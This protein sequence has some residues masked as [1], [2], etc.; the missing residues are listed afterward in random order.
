MRSSKLLT[1]GLS[2]LFSL[3]VVMAAKPAAAQPTLTRFPAGTITFPNTPTGSSS[4]PLVVQIENTGG[5]LS[6]L[7]ITA[8]AL[9][10][11]T[12]Y[13]ILNQTC[14]AHPLAKVIAN[15]SATCVVLLTYRP[16]DG[17]GPDTANLVI[18]SDTGGVP[19]TLTNIPLSGTPTGGTSL[20]A[21]PNVLN[22]GN[23][24]VNAS[25]D[26]KFTEIRNTGTTTI[27]SLVVSALGGTNPGEFAGVQDGCNGQT[28]LP[29]ASCTIQH[30][31]K[32]TSAT[33]GLS[34]TYTVTG[35]ASP[36]LGA[37][38][39][40]TLNGNGVQPTLTTSGP[41]AFGSVMVGTVAGPTTVTVTNTSAVADLHIGNINHGDP[42]H[43]LIS[44]DTC[45]NSTVP[46]G[47]ANTCTFAVRFLPD[48]AVVFNDTINI[49]NDSATTPATVAVSG[50]GVLGTLSSSGPVSFTNNPI[51]V[52]GGPTTVTLTNTDATSSVTLGNLAQIGAD[53]DKFFIS[54]DGCSNAMLA[55]LG[56][57]TFDVSFEAD[58]A[59]SFSDTILVPNNTAVP[60]FT[61]AVTGTTVQP[62]ISI[63]GSGAFG[64]VPI[65]TTAG[66]QTITV[67]NTSAFAD[68][69][70]GTLSKIGADT[71]KFA[72]SNDNC[73][74]Q[75]VAAGGSNTCTFDV[76][77]SPDDT[78]PASDSVLIPNDSAT[79]NTTVSLSGTGE[80]AAISSSGAVSFTNIPVGTTS[81]PSTVTITNTSS[82]VDLHIG[83]LLR[84]GADPAQFTIAND[85]CS[86]ATVAAGG[87]NTC[88]FDVLFSPNAAASF[89]DT[90]LVPNDSN[91]P[92][93][94]VGLSGTG[95]APTVTD[96]G[97]VSFGSVPVG[98]TAG[99]TTVTITNTSA[100]ADLHIGSLVK[101]GANPTNF[102]IA[103]DNCSNATVAAGGSNTCTFDVTFTPTSA[104]SF[105]DTVLIPNDSVADPSLTV[106]LDGDGVVA[107]I[108]S[109]GPIT[110]TNIPI[111]TVGGPTTVIITNTSS[112][113]DLH[114]GNL[115]QIGADSSLFSITNDNCSNQTVPLGGSNTCTF[116]L[117]FSSNAA[118]SFSDTILVPND[119]ASPNFTVAA[120]ATAVQATLTT[121]GAV[122][123]GNIPVGTTSI[124]SL[125]TITNTSADADL[126]IGTLSKIGAN[127]AQFTIQNDNCSNQ[128]VAA[129]GSNTCTFEVTFSPNAAAAFSDTVLIPNDSTTPNATVGLT[130]T[131]VLGGITS[132]GSGAFGNVNVGA[133]G[134]PNTIT[135][136]NGSTTA[137]VK[138]GILQQ[139][140][141]NPNLFSVQNDNCSNVTLAPSPGPGNTCTFQ[142]VF[143]PTAAGSFSDKVLVPNDSTTPNFS[144]NLT[145]TGVVPGVALAQFNPTVLDFDLDLDKNVSA[146]ESQTTTI[147]NV[148]SAPLQITSLAIGG[149]NA[150]AFSET[151]NCAGATLQAGA[152]CTAT[153]TFASN[154]EGD[155]NAA[156]IL[157]SN[158]VGTPFVVLLGSARL[159]NSG[160]C[161]I[162]TG[163]VGTPTAL[164]WGLAAAF[165]GLAALRR[166]AR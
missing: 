77:F 99:P 138:I 39:T 60:N 34:A 33:A 92:N 61:V 58:T 108:S 129:G 101:I 127:P 95:V 47:G 35:T 140:G 3:L 40:V 21:V 110:F 111:G 20:A 109:N 116:D 22:F 130:G 136:T 118:G 153:V 12:N 162:S 83:N 150:G 100:F 17:T 93:F 49:P 19:G 14:T 157:N 135:I 8:V 117:S 25:S 48:S 1:L 122:P 102:A 28:L 137:S 36:A 105:S 155:F 11:A 81:A 73:S 24:L 86:N 164:A 75:T 79:P 134:G 46:K 139:V 90:V 53:T 141:A 154:A 54:N 131:G 96:S 69:H 98:T 87:S 30:L 26:P 121:S 91:T 6:T 71:T 72:I 74:N 15:N 106:D 9:S 161:A 146:S 163:N 147:K 62:A 41:V 133:Q 45:S 29:G 32:P 13:A 160:G 5:I 27:S 80:Q 142:A 57:C 52:V 63:S 23:L 16:A 144:V 148:G 76:T 51:G 56:T 126:H 119:S 120:S 7:N 145:G 67:T 4:L 107:S 149:A 42:V 2:A 143:L 82:T 18:T 123:F 10:S 113:A 128:T 38:I 115:Q 112:D 85:T 165:L 94:T 156:L 88:T 66:P 103:N 125:V 78:N 68:L 159:D 37:P 59:A 65:N 97:D 70:I 104:A 158:S 64:N 31:F 151:D 152:S 44:S 43:F 132:S 166:R 124:P 89:S 114:I 84:I 55:P 50:T